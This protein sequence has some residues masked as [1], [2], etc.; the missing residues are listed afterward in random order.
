[1]KLLSQIKYPIK[2]VLCPTCKEAFIDDLPPVTP[3]VCPIDG[4]T[5][6]FRF[7]KYAD[8]KTY[9]ERSAFPTVLVDPLTPP[10]AQNQELVRS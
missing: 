9:V 10:T 4:V 6:M 5:H 7:D 8:L 3:V 1:M 2:Y